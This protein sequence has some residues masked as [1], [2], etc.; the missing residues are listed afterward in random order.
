MPDTARTTPHRD[1]DALFRASLALLSVVRVAPPD[2]A[3]GTAIITTDPGHRHLLL[4]SPTHNDAER[5]AVALGF[6]ALNPAGTEVDGSRVL[7][8]WAGHVGGMSVHVHHYTDPTTAATDRD[9]S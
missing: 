1:V 5:L 2:V 4:L 7:Y 8:R 3:V 6:T 9:L